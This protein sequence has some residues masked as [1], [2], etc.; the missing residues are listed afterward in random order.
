[1]TIYRMVYTVGI[2]DAQVQFNKM[3][4]YLEEG[5]HIYIQD[6][7]PLTPDYEI[8]EV[9]PEDYKQALYDHFTKKGR[10]LLIDHWQGIEKW[11]YFYL[12]P[13]PPKP[14]FEYP[15]ELVDTEQKAEEPKKQEEPKKKS[16]LAVVF[17]S[18]KKKDVKKEEP[19]EDDLTIK[20]EVVPFPPVKEKTAKRE[21]PVAVEEVEYVPPSK[22]ESKQTKVTKEDAVIPAEKP[23]SKGGR[24]RKTAV[25]K[26]PV[27]E[28]KPAEEPRKRRSKAEVKAETMERGRRLGWRDDDPNNPYAKYVTVLNDITPEEFYG[29]RN[30]DFEGFKHKPTD[31]KEF[32]KRVIEDLRCE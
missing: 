29:L 1:M 18:N 6:I 4:Q 12:K 28:E 32:T 20:P 27:E 30:G 16:V 9:K 3:I 25:P 10:K 11:D 19:K 24:P 13:E 2:T 14:K 5:Q 15:P 8:P 21:Q 22:T 7:D 26:E 17:G 23:K 31:P